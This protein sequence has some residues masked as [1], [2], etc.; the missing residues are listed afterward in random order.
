[1][2]AE[3]GAAEGIAITPDDSRAA[4]SMAADPPG[5]GDIFEMSA[6][7]ASGGAGNGASLGRSVVR[8]ASQRRTASQNATAAVHF[9]QADR[10]AFD[11]V[12]SAILNLQTQVASLQRDLL[13]TEASVLQRIDAHK[14]A[15]Y[16]RFAKEREEMV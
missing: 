1:M 5:I 6:G 11:K 12:G 2:V 13:A 4:M 8:R 10:D 16:Q 7:V 14:H 9:S 3:P 15:M